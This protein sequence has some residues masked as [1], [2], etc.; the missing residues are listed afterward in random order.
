VSQAR[1]SRAKAL[2]PP[3]IRQ[4]ISA[5]R[6]VRTRFLE[7]PLTHAIDRW[8][9]RRSMEAVI[10]RTDHLR[11]VQWLGRSI[12]QFPMDAWLLQEAIVSLK[13]GLIV[14]TGTHRGGSA[15]FFA[16]LF[17]LL[18]VPGEVISIDIAAEDTVPH[19]RITYLA[20][21]S[22]DPDTVRRVA[23]RAGVLGGQVLVILDSDHSSAHVSRELEAY[24]PLVPVGGLLHVQDGWVD[25]LRPGRGF[26]D[27]PT[28]AVK[29][30]LAA[31]PA[32]VR[33]KELEERYLLS[34]HPF[35]W[36][37]RVSRG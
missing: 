32:F 31:N 12:W 29:A 5:R 28:V 1:L 7:T 10:V 37:R 21:S 15:F 17:D 24:A 26:G 20:A 9:F 11:G 35:G 34:L 33:D 18:E 3:G 30:F 6:T 27:G 22:V 16:T 13:P 23:E 8:A 14:E 4:R 2:V 36:L 19:P 25:R